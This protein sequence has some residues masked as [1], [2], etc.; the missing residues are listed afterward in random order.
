[1]S[2][3]WVKS[4]V[5]EKYEVSNMGRIKSLDSYVATVYGAKRLVKG[6]ILSPFYS[7]LTGYLQVKLHGKKYNLHRLIAFA[8]C[9]DGGIEKVVNHKNGQ[10]DD[11]R[12]ENLE[13]VTHSENRL[14]SHRVLGNKGSSHG[15][16]GKDHHTSKPVL[17]MKDGEVIK[18]YESASDA[19]REGSATHSSSVSAC[20]YGKYASHNGYQWKFPE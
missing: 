2:E 7:N 5:S 16:F 6:Q 9:D 10:R 13:W 3:V 4:R 1:M 19:I 14:H 20:C 8:F 12:A 11:N 18:R 17:M 15:K